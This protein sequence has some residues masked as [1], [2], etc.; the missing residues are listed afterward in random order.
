M[1]AS[2]QRLNGETSSQSKELL[3]VF[4]TLTVRP[5]K[6]NVVDAPSAR[7]WMMFLSNL[8]SVQVS[9]PSMSAHEGFRPSG[10][11]EL[12]DCA[13]TVNAARLASRSPE[14][15]TTAPRLAMPVV[16]RARR[17]KESCIWG[18]ALLECQRSLSASPHETPPGAARASYRGYVLESARKRVRNF[19][20]A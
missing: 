15:T 14:P 1:T 12:A 5:S 11:A 10:G 18:T 2:I 19:N 20:W 13:P 7:S 17:A 9:A 16:P 4:V 8:C 3:P 6:V